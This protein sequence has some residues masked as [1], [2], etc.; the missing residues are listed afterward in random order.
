MT[1]QR[2]QGQWVVDQDFDVNSL[3]IH[4]AFLYTFPTPK[5]VSFGAI[6]DTYFLNNFL[7]QNSFRFTEKLQEYH[8]EFL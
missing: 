6:G 7:F 1:G 5:A 4:E 3:A 8:R 2:Q